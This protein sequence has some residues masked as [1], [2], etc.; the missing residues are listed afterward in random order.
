MLVGVFVG[1]IIGPGLL[2]MDHDRPYRGVIVMV[3][4]ALMVLI[5]SGRSAGVSR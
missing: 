4:A 5:S 3:L 2:V 1:G